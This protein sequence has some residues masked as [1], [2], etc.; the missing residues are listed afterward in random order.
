VLKRLPNL[1]AV[2]VS[3]WADEAAMAEA[4]GRDVLYCRKP[5]PAMISTPH[6]DEGAIR[7]DLRN[8]L[9]AAKGCNVEIVM[10]DIHTLAGEKHRPARWV[11]LAREEC[12]R[13]GL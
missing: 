2:S 3:P 6:F 11:E 13:I 5:N 4:C 7:A 12:A 10:K 8:T 9:K 1:R